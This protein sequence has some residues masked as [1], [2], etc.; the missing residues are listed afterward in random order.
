MFRGTSSVQLVLWTPQRI[1]RQ[2]EQLHA[3]YVLTSRLHELEQSGVSLAAMMR[4]KRAFARVLADT[5]IAGR[6]ELAPASVRQL[7][8]KNKMRTLYGLRLTD[9]LVHR[10][11]TQALK[12]A[13]TPIISQRLYSYRKGQSSSSAVKDFAA[14][15]RMHNEERPDPRQRGLYVIRRDIAAYTD[16]IPVDDRSPLWGMLRHML[17]R[18][19]SLN[20]TDWQLVV[21]TVRPDVRGTDGRLSVLS[22]GVPT[23]LP[24]ACALF[25]LYLTPIDQVLDSVSG[26]FYAR[27]SDDILFAHPI[28]DVATSATVTIDRVV[29]ELGLTTSADKH[30]DLYLTAA[31]RRSNHWPE[32]RVAMAVPLL[33]FQITAHGTVSLGRKKVRR[34]L[35]EVKHRVARTSAVCAVGDGATVGP[36]VCAVVNRILRR[37]PFPVYTS[38]LLARVVTDRHQLRQLD[39]WIS[40]IV[41]QAATGSRTARGFRSLPYRRIRRQWRLRSLVHAR[42]RWGR[43]S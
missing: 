35:R 18:S 31:G 14:Y 39:Y 6:Y 13:M 7:R 9:L 15:V 17:T 25:N 36:L 27:Y 26:G 8:I 24:I 22:R 28:A 38:S 32:S 2:I 12:E 21:G 4:N 40:R 37:G 23:G 29:G 30:G 43:G 10:V 5:L 1:E 41:M 3:R 34:F 11:I 19:F 33:G 16:S 20:E 42:N